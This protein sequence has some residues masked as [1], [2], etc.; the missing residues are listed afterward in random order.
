MTLDP[1]GNPGKS[2]HLK[3][4]NLTPSTNSL[5]LCKVTDSQVPG[6]RVWPPLAGEDCV[7][8]HISCQ[9]QNS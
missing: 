2:P 7:S 4:L 9:G 3:T 1:P 5:L 6:I 8:N